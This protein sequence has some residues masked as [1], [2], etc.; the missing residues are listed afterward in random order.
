MGA[1]EQRITRIMR[2]P[3][4]ELIDPAHQVC[5]DQVLIG[6]WRLPQADSGALVEFGL[7]DD[8][9]MQPEYQNG[10]EPRL[11]YATDSDRLEPG[12]VARCEAYDLGRWGANEFTPTIGVQV[13]QGRILAFPSVAQEPLE[14]CPVEGRECGHEPRLWP[15]LLSSSLTQFVSISWRWRAARDLMLN[16]PRVEWPF[17]EEDVL[18]EYD[19]RESYARLILAEIENIDPALPAEVETPWHILAMDII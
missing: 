11:A 9:L 18:T 4:E 8:L 16:L 15:L 10:A 3:L 14:R 17:A 1:V 6:R 12:A 7:P 13:D 2:G 19:Q 5:A